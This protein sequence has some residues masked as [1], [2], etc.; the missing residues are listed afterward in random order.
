ML[1]GAMDSGDRFHRFGTKSMRE[2]RGG[3]GG[4]GGG[5]IGAETWGEG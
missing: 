2:K 1:A 4:G 5:F 3:K